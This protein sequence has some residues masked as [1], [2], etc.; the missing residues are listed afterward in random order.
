MS[1]YTSIESITDLSI[2]QKELHKKTV[3]IVGLGIIGSSVAQIFARVGV[4]L[5]IIDKDR[6]YEEDMSML[7]LFGNEHI[8]KFKAKE[9]KKLLENINADIKV[10]AF[11]E[12][13][14]DNNAF[15]VESDVIIDCS[16][17]LK[18]S[19]LVD[20]AAKD[21]PVIYTRAGCTKAC[22]YI[23]HETRL[24]EI[25]PFLEKNTPEDK[26]VLPSTSMIAAGLAA[27][28]ALKILSGQKYEKN[29]LVIDDWKY[30]FEKI[31]VRKSKK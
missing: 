20:K 11:H 23:A 14:V 10:K 24:T 21:T 2:T 15:L 18:T 31:P 25:I 7:S 16:N 17:N 19:L 1:R 29:F 26:A 8:S 30:S 22:V 5:R 3:T 28:K 9:G 6:V 27:N 12:E 4:N 13:L